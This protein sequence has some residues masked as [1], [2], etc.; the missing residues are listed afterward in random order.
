MKSRAIKC[1]EEKKRYMVYNV[2]LDKIV[3]DAVTKDFAVWDDRAAAEQMARG[4]E[5]HSD[6]LKRTNGAGCKFEVVEVA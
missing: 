5:A 3:R 6:R 4:L 2:T 1:V